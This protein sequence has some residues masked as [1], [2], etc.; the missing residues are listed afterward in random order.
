MADLAQFK[1]LFDSHGVPYV[2]QSINNADAEDIAR[3]CKEPAAAKSRYY[4]LVGG[5]SFHFNAFGKYI[6]IEHTNFEPREGEED[7]DANV[8]GDRGRSS[9]QGSAGVPSS[10]E[11]TDEADVGD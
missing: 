11:A 3:S 8:A 6:G 10:D 5:T 1:K 2:Q 9:E 7:T 4:L